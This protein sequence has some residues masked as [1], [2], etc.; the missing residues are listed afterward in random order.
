MTPEE[1]EAVILIFASR[2]KVYKLLHDFWINEPGEKQLEELYDPSLKVTLELLSP[3]EMVPLSS[4]LEKMQVNYEEFNEEYL[5]DIQAQYHQMMQSVEVHLSA[6][7]AVKYL[8]LPQDELRE[9]MLM[10]GA[11]YERY[12]ALHNDSS[13]EAD[14]YLAVELSFMGRASGLAQQAIELGIDRRAQQLLEE[15]EWFLND[16]LLHWVPKWEAEMQQSEA[17]D[18]YRHLAA[19]T[20]QFLR[21]DS[22]AME[23]LL[24][25]V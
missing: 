11:T 24:E 23:D 9:E 13:I 25:I 18:F 12:G 10:V 3:D 21:Y 2:K 5:K 15:Q 19:L 7:F 20:V 22:M 14:S 8:D 6:P 1:R 16:H 4:Y 17:A